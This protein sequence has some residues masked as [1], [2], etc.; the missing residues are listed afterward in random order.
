MEVGKLKTALLNATRKGLYANRRVGPSDVEAQLIAQGVS[1]RARTADA[2]AV[3]RLEKGCLIKVR[4][5]VDKERGKVGDN[6]PGRGYAFAEFKHHAHALACLRE[7]NDNAEYDSLATGHSAQVKEPKK[8]EGRG[9]GA[10]KKKGKDRQTEAGPVKS[11]LVVEFAVEDAEKM[12]V[13]RKRKEHLS[14]AAQRATQRK[15]TSGDVFET[16][17]SAEGSKIGSKRKTSMNE[18][19]TDTPGVK[20]GRTDGQT[21]QS[22][23]QQQQQ[24]QQ[25]K[26]KGK[27]KDKGKPKSAEKEV[28]RKLAIQKRR[29][30]ELK[31]QIGRASH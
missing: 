10:G 23:K 20:R 7:L 24:Q 27:I 15:G 16:E 14:A 17:A 6:A 12:Q 21:T 9:D 29:A 19:E 28:K 22:G 2:C 18:E 25:Q 1:V 4:V 31:R 5:L 13:L 8:R 26:K 3:P 30:K 11:R